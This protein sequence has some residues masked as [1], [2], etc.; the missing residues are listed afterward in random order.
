MNGTEQAVV[1]KTIEVIKKFSFVL[2]L[3]KTENMRINFSRKKILLSFIFSHYLI[4]HYHELLNRMF[5]ILL[6]MSF[7]K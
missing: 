4:N 5:F 6:L 1:W 3:N 2:F 7:V